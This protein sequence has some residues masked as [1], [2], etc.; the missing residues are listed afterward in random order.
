VIKV[1][2]MV[3]V[4][5]LKNV[6]VNLVHGRDLMEKFDLGFKAANIYLKQEI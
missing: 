5:P 4:S 6:N 3:L 1:K 2:L